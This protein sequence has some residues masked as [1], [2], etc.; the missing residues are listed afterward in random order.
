MLLGK[1]DV[2]YIPRTSSPPSHLKHIQVVL[3]VQVLVLYV[4]IAS[5]NHNF[6]FS[7]KAFSTVVQRTNPT[8]PAV[9]V[10]YEGGNQAT[11]IASVFNQDQSPNMNPA[12]V[13]DQIQ[14]TVLNQERLL[15]GLP[16]M[17]MAV[18][19]VLMTNYFY[20][21][22]WDY[23]DKNLDSI[24][25]KYE[26][27]GAILSMAFC[28]LVIAFLLLCWWSFLP[29]RNPTSLDKCLNTVAIIG[30]YIGGKPQTRSRVV[31]I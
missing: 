7:P 8:T 13:F 31:F 2:G 17:M 14:P 29:E 20:L 16:R 26:A 25:T 6:V 11:N 22:E 27:V 12:S 9:P 19:V 5:Y 28:F 3:T 23:Y 18:C 15:V 30:G 4:T 10:C 21:Y 24:G 1:I